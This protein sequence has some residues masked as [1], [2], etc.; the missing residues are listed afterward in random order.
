MRLSEGYVVEKRPVSILRKFPNVR[1]V[2]NR[3]YIE[4]V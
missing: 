1:K 2:I 3:T 4:S